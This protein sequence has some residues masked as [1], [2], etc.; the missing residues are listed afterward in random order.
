[1]RLGGFL[2]YWPWFS[3]QEQVTLARADDEL[4]LDS[5]WVSEA[6]GQDAVP[7]LAMPF[8]DREAIVRTLAG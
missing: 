7:L 1:V 3:F 6:R 5:V 2:A 8:G 4:G